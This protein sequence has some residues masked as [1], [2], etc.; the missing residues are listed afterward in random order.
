[1][2]IYAGQNVSARMFNRL[3]PEPVSAS[4]SSD[5]TVTGTTTLVPGCEITLTVE[6]AGARIIADGSVNFLVGGV[7][8]S[9]SSYCSAQLTLDGVTMPGFA[10]WGDTVIGAQ[11]TPSKQWDLTNLAA[12]S[13]TIRLAAART[14]AGTGTV[15]AVGANS[16]LVVWLYEPV[17]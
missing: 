15:T 9:A 10:R 11:G 7:T 4:G 16:Q 17:V 8:L 6:T 5:L 12:G 14:S 2:T 3:R 13:H 1:M